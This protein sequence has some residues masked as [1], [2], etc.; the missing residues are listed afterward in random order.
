MK[1]KYTFLAMILLAGL[2]SASAADFYSQNFDSMGTTGTAMP[3][4]WSMWYLAG[5]S[6]S[7]VAPTGAEMAT[8]SGGVSQLNVWN[9]TDPTDAWSQQAA[10]MG[11][12]AT[13]PNRLL[14][15]SPTGTRGSILQLS[16]NNNTGTALTSADLSYDM[17]VM[18]P[19][20]LKSGMPLDSTDELPGYRF[21]FLDGA[22]WKPLTSLD[23]S[24]SGTASATVNYSTPVANGGTLQFRWFDDNAAA[25]DPDSMI[26]I[27][28]VNLTV[29]EPTTLSLLALGAGALLLRR[30]KA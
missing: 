5:S 26:A 27:D 16:L 29:P 17:Q 25:F 12:S 14:G 24:V 20:T 23:L 21:Y 2:L 4:G 3:A 10:N 28:N 15:T 19:G 18:A 6:S 22:T 9:Q 8:A 13:D 30:R 7:L 1:T 11:S